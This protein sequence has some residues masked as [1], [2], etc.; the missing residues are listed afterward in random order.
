MSFE[1]FVSSQSYYS[2]IPMVLIVS[3]IVKA[4]KTKLERQPIFLIDEVAEMWSVK[5]QQTEIAVQEFMR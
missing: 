3:T 5:P 4:I 2:D 1:R